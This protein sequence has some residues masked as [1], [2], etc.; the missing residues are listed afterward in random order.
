MSSQRGGLSFR[1]A[2]QSREMLTET[3]TILGDKGDK[4]RNLV[5]SNLRLS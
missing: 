5:T 4:T 1:F 3:E 2:Q